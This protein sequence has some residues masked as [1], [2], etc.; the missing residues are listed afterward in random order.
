MELTFKPTDKNRGLPF[1]EKFKCKINRVDRV[2]GILGALK[3][4]RRNDELAEIKNKCKTEGIE[5]QVRSDSR[6]EKIHFCL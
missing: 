3:A 2:A 5:M 1:L 4:S 6:H